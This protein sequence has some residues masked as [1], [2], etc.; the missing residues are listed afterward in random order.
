[1]LE[2]GVLSFDS[3]MVN[4]YQ[5]EVGHYSVWTCNKGTFICSASIAVTVSIISSRK[6]RSV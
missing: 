2:E 4:S 3:D 1:M 5:L 6:S